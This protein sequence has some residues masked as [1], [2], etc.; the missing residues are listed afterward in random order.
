M[1]FPDIVTGVWIEGHTIRIREI[2]I[3]KRPLRAVKVGNLTAEHNPA[4]CLQPDDKFF[5]FFIISGNSRHILYQM[6]ISCE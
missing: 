6:T 1:N 3:R 2:G 5:S 4:Q